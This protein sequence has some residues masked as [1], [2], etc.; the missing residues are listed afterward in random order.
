[1]NSPDNSGGS[2][3]V[4]DSDTDNF[5]TDVI[6]LSKEVPVIVDF[7]APWCGPCKQLGPALEKVVNE[8]GGTVRMVKVNVDENQSLAG[9]MGVQSIPA[10]FAFK[11]GQPVDGF[12]GALPES[13]IKAFIEKLGVAA[14]PSPEGPDIEA[15]KAALEEGDLENAAKGFVA[16]LKEDKENI[17]AV[18][19]LAVI[20]L[21]MG[22][23]PEARRTIE[24]LPDDKQKDPLLGPVLARIE[25]AEKAADLGE[26]GDLAAKVASDPN[27]HQ[28]RFD[29][30][31]AL[32]AAGDRGDAVDHLLEIIKRKNDWNEG[33]ARQQLLQLFEA[34]GP[35]D[36]VTIEGRRQLS[37]VLF[38]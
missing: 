19:G 30:A 38:S 3:F 27:D 13:E 35:A 17:D 1:M 7:W 37:I 33:A 18:A 32:S 11:D 2:A 15:A 25:L 23:P 14:A 21:E 28:A 4:K 5:I 16:V 26:T 31:L 24:L 6:E 9:Q 20:H 12:M 10:V 29:L 36:P 8:M 34:W 22:A